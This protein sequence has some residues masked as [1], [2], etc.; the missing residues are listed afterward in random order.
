MRVGHDTY[1]TSLAKKGDFDHYGMT[2]IEVMS[3]TAFSCVIC[4]IGTLSNVL[5]TIA[6]LLTRELRKRYTAV[7]L[8]SM[9][10]TDTIICAV[11]EPMYI[12]DINHG[13]S[14]VM[15]KVRYRLGFCL[16]LASLN[17]QLT[18][19]LDRFI[20]IFYPYQYIALTNTR[21]VVLSAFFIQWFNAILLTLL[22]L[23]TS[24][25]V[26]SVVYV[27]VI[28]IGL[29]SLH[30]SMYCAAQ[31]HQRRI[32]RQYPVVKQQVLFVWNK[33][34]T[35]ISMTLVATLLCWAPIMIL[36]A[37]MSPSSPS[38]K[39]A[40]K[41]TLAFT[42]LSAAVNPFIFFWRL[43]DFR[44]ALVTCLRGLYTV[45]HCDRASNQ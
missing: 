45:F 29:A 18:V 34:T 41:V 25:P 32:A 37:V 15:E 40:V 28:V 16:L 20:N 2:L 1:N 6:V 9:S 7:F 23:L 3:L 24:R 33:S 13:S 39:R 27:A 38:F 14:A 10:V 36:P 31:Q 43:K 26:F 5:L 22:S 17:G 19:T 42:T 44:T 4:M 8:I 12:Y 30:I 35:V 21:F 11:Y